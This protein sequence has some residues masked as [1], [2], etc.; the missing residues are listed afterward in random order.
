MVL[1]PQRIAV[2]KFRDTLAMAY[3]WYNVVH[4][5]VVVENHS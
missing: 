2:L 5:H 1:I 3:K 4:E